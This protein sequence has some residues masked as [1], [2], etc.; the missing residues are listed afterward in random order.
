MFVIYFIFL[1]HLNAST[2]DNVIVAKILT[3]LKKKIK[4]KIRNKK[5]A[6]KKGAVS[7]SR[8]FFLC[9]KYLKSYNTVERKVKL[10]KKM[11]LHRKILIIFAD[12][13]RLINY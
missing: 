11:P 7:V 6:N 2:C 1:W 13:F 5:I 8:F 10:S 12:N 4:K 3:I 9:S